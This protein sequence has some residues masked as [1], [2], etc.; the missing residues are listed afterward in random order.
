MIES[1]SQRK[2]DKN[3]LEGKISKQNLF[4]SKSK[5]IPSA[6]NS[7]LIEEFN[8][9]INKYKNEFYAIKDKKK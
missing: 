1:Y 5:N 8:K 2:K 4:R 7:F 9:V 3:N 6:G